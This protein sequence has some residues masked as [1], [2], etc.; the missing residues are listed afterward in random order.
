MEP[1]TKHPSRRP[2]RRRRAVLV[3]LLSLAG[4]LLVD[5]LAAGHEPADLDAPSG[6][7]AVVLAAPATFTDDVSAKFKV[8]YDEGGTTVANV[9]D[10]ASNV[11]IARVT[12]QPG[13]TSG[14]HTHPG[15]V[16]VTVTE[17]TLEVTNASDCVTRTYTAGEAFVDPGQGNVHV[18]SNASDEAGAVAHAVF[19]DVPSGQPA[20]VWAEPADC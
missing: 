4:A 13:G 16:I 6:F 3:A 20:T 17:G 15:P 1:R 18:A 10:D 7:G 8:K 12:W 11:L 19:L 5:G 14:W 2:I 9:T